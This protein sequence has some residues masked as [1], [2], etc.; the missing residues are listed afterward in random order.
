MP[1]SNR[2]RHRLASSSAGGNGLY[3]YG[4]TNTAGLFPTNTFNSNKTGLTWR[5][6]RNSPEGDVSKA[7]Q[8]QGTKTGHANWASG[9]KAVP[10]TSR[11]ANLGSFCQK[12]FIAELRLKARGPTVLSVG[13]PLVAVQRY[14]RQQGA[15]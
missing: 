6:V 15:A 5:S 12:S 14:Q 8:P 3:A 1:C 11:W 7:R 4:G 10:M 13:Q 9:K 2:W